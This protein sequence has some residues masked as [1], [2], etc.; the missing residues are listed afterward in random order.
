[1]VA[2]GALL[3]SLYSKLFL[4]TCVAHLLYNCVL[5]VRSNFQDVDQ[6]IAKLKYVTVKTKPRQAKFATSS[7]A[8][9]DRALP[10]A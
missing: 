1:M 4:L 3:K 9:G 10:L 8:M 5:K 6:V 2:A 7:V